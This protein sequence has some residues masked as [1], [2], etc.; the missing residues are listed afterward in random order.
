MV[1]LCSIHYDIFSF[2]A[3]AFIC[4]A[5]NPS[6]GMLSVVVE[7]MIHITFVHRHLRQQGKV[8]DFNCFPPC[9]VWCVV[10]TLVKTQTYKL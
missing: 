3:S 7:F 9:F 6:V 2:N 1:H 5:S 8:F 4:C 10:V